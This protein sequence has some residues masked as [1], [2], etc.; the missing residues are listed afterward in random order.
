MAYTI[1]AGLLI[2]LAGMIVILA[3]RM[4][5]KGNWLFGWLKG[6]TGILLA[7]TAVLLVLMALD[8]HSYKQFQQEQSIANLSFSKIAPQHFTVSLV[9]SDGVEWVHELKGDLWQLDAKIIK[10]N[11][12]IAGLGLSPG[13]RLDR[14]SGRYYSLE[15]E[16][17]EQRTVYQLESSSTLDLWSWLREYGQKINILDASYGSATYLPMEDGALFSVTLS[18]TG[19][20]TRPL[21]SRAKAAVDGWR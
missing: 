9:D 6:M 15:M 17:S 4:L 7:T 14:L 21:N 13:Y 12:T 3:C 18:N 19:L 11:T 16:Q 5:F 2:L 8:F 1:L 20:L 10:W